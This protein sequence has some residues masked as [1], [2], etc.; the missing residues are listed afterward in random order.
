M[1]GV[2]RIDLLGCPFD[3]ISFE[4][5]VDAIR[6]AVVR[7]H[8]LQIVPGSV[9]TVMK[10]RRDPAFL[11]DL[12]RADLVVADGQFITWAAQAVGTP[13]RKR[14]SGTELVWHCARVS[15]ETGCTV[16][17]IGAAPGVA[18]RA[19]GEMR[20]HWPGSDVRALPTPFPLDAAANA[21]LVAQLRAM[22]AAIVLAALGAPRQERWVRDHIGESGIA[23]SG[24]RV[25]IGIGSA[26]DII[27]GDMRRAPMWMQRLSL[28]WFH[29]LL[30]EP[31]RLGRRYLIEDMPFVALLARE[32]LRRRLAR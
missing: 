32:A 24:A 11:A 25:G 9:D 27:C 17:L 18:D 4:A 28:E 30:L 5:T 3:A 16:A 19:A 6:D 14:V 29:R 15:A 31:R 26:F 23:A 12:T 13:L 1:L 22:D 10:S 20:K 7:G 21:A 8:S 2:D